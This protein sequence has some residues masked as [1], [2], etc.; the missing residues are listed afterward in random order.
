[1]IIPFFFSFQAPPTSLLATFIFALLS[2][3]FSNIFASRIKDTPLDIFI[4][5]V[6]CAVLSGKGVSNFACSIRKP[7][8]RNCILIFP[9]FAPFCCCDIVHV[10]S[11]N[12][13]TAGPHPRGVRQGNTGLVVGILVLCLDS[14]LHS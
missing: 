10:N 6:N 9:T 7:P 14:T 1:M 12:Y 5:S 8:F 11:E 4:H 3:L 2:V 13:V